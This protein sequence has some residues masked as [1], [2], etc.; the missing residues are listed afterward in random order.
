MEGPVCPCLCV[1][2]CEWQCSCVCEAHVCAKVLATKYCTPLCGIVA[3]LVLQDTLSIRK[4]NNM[5]EDSVLRGKCISK[6]PIRSYVS[7]QPTLLHRRCCHMLKHYLE[8]CIVC[9]VCW[10]PAVASALVAAVTSSVF[11]DKAIKV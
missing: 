8:F 11:H 1:C 3:M 10:V 9:S 7:I 2:V 6:L 4:R 5:I